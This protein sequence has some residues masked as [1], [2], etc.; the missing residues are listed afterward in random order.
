MNSILKEE[1]HEYLIQSLETSRAKLLDLTRRNRLLSYRESARDVGFIDEM[2]DQVYER[3]RAGQGFALDPLDE[4]V[5]SEPGEELDRS[6]PKSLRRDEEVDERYRDDRLQTAFRERDLERRLRRLY[7][8]HR[9]SIEETGAN[10]LYL[11]MGFLRWYDSEDSEAAFVSPLLL[12]PVRLERER[13]FG[14]S[15]YKLVPNE[16]DL[17]T[18]Y[19]LAEKLWKNFDIRLP[20]VNDE[21]TPESYWRAVL[22]AIGPARRARWTVVREMAL[23]L[24]RFQKQVMWHDLDPDRW[25]S[26]TPLLDHSMLRR[27]LLGPQ[28]GEAPPGQLSHEY[29][30]DG[31]EAKDA[32]HDLALVRDA[33]SSQYAAL[34]DALGRQ[35]GLVIE[36][37]PGTG[38]SQTITNLIAAALAKGEKVLFVA[39]KMAALASSEEAPGRCRSW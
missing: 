18:N 6:L 39:E 10:A 21:C 24:F 28:Q 25:P 9:S 35:D 37:P 33:D 3:L 30:Q 12:I 23:G 14:A 31:D 1:H 34:V 17:D 29:A 27:V 16:Q 26:E 22:D 32:G 19:A 15:V 4:H 7:S 2:P 20:E 5:E 8:D 36:G 11:A 13:G 38:K